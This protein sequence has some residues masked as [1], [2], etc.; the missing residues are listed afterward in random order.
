MK[1]IKQK[2]TVVIALLITVLPLLVTN[3]ARGQLTINNATVNGSGC[4][5]S[6]ILINYSE[7]L[8][9]G[10]Y[11]S[12]IE[13]SDL[14]GSFTNV[15]N[16]QNISSG[17][18]FPNKWLSGTIPNGI[19]YGTGYRVRIVKTNISTS[20]ITTSNSNSSDL[21]INE[22]PN[23]NVCGETIYGS[24]S[25]NNCAGSIFFNKASSLGTPS[26]SYS[27]VLSG[28]TTGSGTGTGSGATFN[29]GTTSVTITPSNACGQGNNC[30]IYVS[31][32]DN[33]IPQIIAPPD[34]VING[35][36]AP[37]APL[38]SV[39]LGAAT[40]SDN[41]GI[42]SITNN[43][44][45]I[46][47]TGVHTT[48]TWTATDIN[49]N[50]ATSNQDVLVNPGH[51]SINSVVTPE[52]PVAGQEE[53]TV[54]LGYPSG[55][56]S[57]SYTITPSGGTAPYQYEWQVM[58]CS[59]SVYST[60]NKTSNNFTFEPTTADTC[61]FHGD[62]WYDY[63][64]KITDAHNCFVYDGASFN[65]VNPYVGTIG[66]SNLLL[67]HTM[68]TRG[69]TIN[70]LL[71]LA[72][73]QTTTHLQHGDQLGH[74]EPV[75]VPIK[76]LSAEE[77]LKEVALYPNPSNGQVSVDIAKFS[78][79]VDITI[80]DV[81]GRLIAHKRLEVDQPSTISFDLRKNAPGVYFVQI[82]DGEFS[83]FRKLI[84]K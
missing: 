37:G 50:Q 74:C 16:L 43:A 53:R 40:A 80:S 64:V 27:Y 21:T 30:T 19:P 9:S 11:Q 6:T 45:S 63:W 60:L 39:S 38:D 44:P 82:G 83:Y 69:R 68:R 72:P 28:S 8:P 66:N 35:Y 71:S 7:I 67:C 31:V 25:I 57:I 22:V 10:Q 77:D 13:L 81:Q 20:V 58:S 5:G 42:F 59:S 1:L 3:K 33:T 48:V 32:T 54:Y 78:E 76:Q 46:F 62:N 61:S 49:G 84:L 56:S 24:T 70:Q 23:F 14:S 52:Y 55:S 17:F 51:I 41:C 29:K 36:C 15:V 47:P 2:S 18:S 34:L 26:P 4:P 12:K 75:L 79:Q 65:V 73:N